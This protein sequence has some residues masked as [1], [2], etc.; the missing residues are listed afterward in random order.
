MSLA[1]YRISMDLAQEGVPVKIG[2]MTFNIRQ[3][4]DIET[5]M[6]QLSRLD[7]D[8]HI[9]DLERAREKLSIVFKELVAGWSGVTAS[10]LSDYVVSSAFYE[11]TCEYDL[12]DIKFKLKRIT[13]E[14][15]ESFSNAGTSEQIRSRFL[16]EH[17]VGWDNLVLEEGGKKIPFSSH[18][19]VEIFSDPEIKQVVKI[20]QGAAQSKTRFKKTDL[21]T[22]EI[23]YSE[24]NVRS[25]MIN[26]D[27][28][29]LLDEI[30]KASNNYENFRYEMVKKDSEEVKKQ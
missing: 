17:V 12:D 18:A 10:R 11:D 5:V 21:D 20:L 7:S 30:I 28:N 27:E 16:R 23:P 6:H 29:D 15:R 1:K 4:D 3:P 9:S 22:K 2:G 24:F 25:Y 13:L 26:V 8:R 14:D 19:A